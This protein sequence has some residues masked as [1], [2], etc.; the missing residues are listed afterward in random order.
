MK[1]VSW[2]VNGI[3][4]CQRAGFLDWFAKQDADVVC[5]QETKAHV[6]QLEDELSRPLGYHA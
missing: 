6:D 1:I 2:N 3:R 4:A 5:I